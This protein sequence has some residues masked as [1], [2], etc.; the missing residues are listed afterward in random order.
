MPDIIRILVIDDHPL[1]RDGVCS[2]LESGDNFSVVGQGASYDDALKLAHE[3]V[4][5]MIFL[6]ISMPGG[7]VNAAR[8]IHSALPDIKLVMLTV[9][10]DEKDVISA[11]KAGA[12][13][14]ILKYSF[15]HQS[16]G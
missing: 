12:K 14:Y 4:P 6:D 7:G 1:L 3:H 5:D 15:R 8:D 11:L 13:G 10:E 9:S 2:T 16:S